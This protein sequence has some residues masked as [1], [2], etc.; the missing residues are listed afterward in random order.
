MFIKHMLKNINK[1]RNNK[2][3]YNEKC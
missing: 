2:H 1:I 3:L